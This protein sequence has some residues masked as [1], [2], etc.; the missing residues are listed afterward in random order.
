MIG[1][2]EPWPK[3][4][5]YKLFLDKLIPRLESLGEKGLSVMV[6]GSFVTEQFIPGISDIDIV[7]IFPYDVV[8]DK[9][10]MGEFSKVLHQ[11][12]SE[13]KIP[14]QPSP[15]DTTTMR[16]GR[17][18]SFMNEFDYY[19]TK[20]GKIVIGPD[21][22]KEIRL[23]ELKKGDEGALSHNLRKMR[24]GLMY[25]ERDK[26]N[27]YPRFLEKFKA[28]MNAASR[29]AKQ[30]IYLS[31]GGQR[32]NRFSA[33]GELGKEFPEVDIEPLKE[34]KYLYHNLKRME[35][36]YHNPEEAMRVYNSSAT[37]LEEV[38]RA[39]IRK[40]PRRKNKTKSL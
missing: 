23:M 28:T 38:V 18:N 16:D 15:L 32:E 12:L 31:S 20:Q 7:I 39:Y 35:K 14:F 26:E 11:T 27:D 34:I 3:R 17:F 9:R 10:F 36:V 25:A 1:Y 21:Y 24:Q 4:K 5:D 2:D 33:L 30:I 37:F 19:F 40:H 8:I 29:G 6:H 13:H 22:R